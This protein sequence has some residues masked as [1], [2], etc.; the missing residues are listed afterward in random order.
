M[1]IES[2][3]CVAPLVG[4]AWK[5]TGLTWGGLFGIYLQS[6]L[7][8]VKGTLPVLRASQLFPDILCMALYFYFKRYTF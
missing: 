5:R 8:I 2:N 6:V 3:I 4:L 1:T 7:L